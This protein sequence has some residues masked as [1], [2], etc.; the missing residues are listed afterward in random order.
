MPF[1]YYGE[2]KFR[3]SLDLH[4]LVKN[5]LD[6]GLEEYKVSS[7]LELIADNVESGTCAA[8]GMERPLITNDGDVYC[9]YC[10]EKQEREYAVTLT[11]SGTI[12]IYVTASSEDAASD[13]AVERWNNDGEDAGTIEWDD[14]PDVDSVEVVW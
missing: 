3:Q 12:R 2:A 9:L 4:L 1:P 7:A 5:L 11:V 10:R 13:M 6:Q 14:D 8:E